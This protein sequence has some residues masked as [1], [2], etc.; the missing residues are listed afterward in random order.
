M[1]HSAYPNLAGNASVPLDGKIT[2]Q[3]Q[4]EYASDDNN[5]D[6]KIKTINI[7][8]LNNNDNNIRI[9][10]QII[11]YEQMPTSTNGMEI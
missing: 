9:C 8:L 5:D 4:T 6:N 2:R 7:I 10:V 1:L 11:I 3:N